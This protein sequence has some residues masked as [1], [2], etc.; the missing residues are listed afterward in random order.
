MRT[1]SLDQRSDAWHEWRRRGIGASEAPILLGEGYKKTPFMLWQE[2]CGFKD[3]HVN[4]NPA[5]QHGITTEPLAQKWANE[6]L[7]TNCAPIC[8]ED[9]IRPYIRASLDGWDPD[10]L[11]L[12][13]IKCPISES[14]L[15]NARMGIVPASWT[16]QV[17]WQMMISAPRKAYLV[18][19]DHR[20]RCGIILE[21]ERSEKYISYLST[22]AEKFWD[23]VRFGNA[24]PLCAEDYEKK[25]GDEIREAVEE[26]KIARDAKTIVDKNFSEARARLT[27]FGS[28]ENFQSYGIKAT[29][30]KGKPSY[31][32]AKM[33]ED[34][35]DLSAYLKTEP[36]DHYRFTV[37]KGEA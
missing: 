36:K 14:R 18:V 23:D 6:H 2:K 8:V 20:Y 7:G 15:D 4:V 30:M 24:P 19:W 31:D 17:Q 28:G 25:E 35:V 16:L 22:A 10:E 5:M 1:V 33:K 13:E 12:M 21:Q 11:V 37:E 27:S 3:S 26:F 34:G 32:V 9:E 29:Y